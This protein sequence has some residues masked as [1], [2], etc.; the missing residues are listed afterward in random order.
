[1]VPLATCGVLQGKKPKLDGGAHNDAW[2]AHTLCPQLLAEGLQPMI[3][4]A[5]PHAVWCACRKQ[6][7]LEQWRT[8]VSAMR[9]GRSHGLLSGKRPGEVHPLAEKFIAASQQ[10]PPPHLDVATLRK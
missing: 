9:G 1:M 8:A 5:P 10:Q 2:V 3:E 7:A 4:R 6:K